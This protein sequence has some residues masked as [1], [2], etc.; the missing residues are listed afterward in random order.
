MS[1]VEIVIRI[2]LLV[3]AIFAALIINDRVQKKK[4]AP[5]TNKEQ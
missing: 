2:L 5:P 4:H 1:G 3:G